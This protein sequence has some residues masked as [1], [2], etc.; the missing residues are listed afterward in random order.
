MPKS[1]PPIRSYRIIDLGSASS[2]RSTASRLAGPVSFGGPASAR[3]DRHAVQRRRW[4]RAYLTARVDVLSRTSADDRSAILE[5]IPAGGRLALLQAPD[6]TGGWLKDRLLNLSVM[7]RATRAISHVMELDALLP[8]I[9]ELVFES[10]STDRGAILLKDDN[11]LLVHQGR[12][13]A[14]AQPSPDE[15]DDD[16]PDDR[17][18]RPR[19]RAGVITSDASGD[20]RFGPRGRSSTMGSAK[21]DLRPVPGRHAILGV[22]YADIRAASGFMPTTF[23]RDGVRSRFSQDHL[24]L[25]AAIGH[26]AGLAIENTHFYN[27]KIQAER[28]AAV[29]QA[30][31]H[32]LAP[33][34]RTSCRDPGRELSDRH[35]AEREGRRDRPSWLDHRR[36]E[37]RQDLQHGHGHALLLQGSRACPL[38]PND[39]NETIT[40]VVEL[41]QSRAKELGVELQWDPGANLDQVMID[42]DGIHR[43]IL[44]ILTNAIDA[45]EG[46]TN[47]RVVVKTLH[48]VDNSSARIT[49]ADNGI[50]ID[51]DDLASIFQVFSSSKGSRGTGPGTPRL[52][53]DHPRARRQDC[54]HLEGRPGIN[55]R[56]R[57]PA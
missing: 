21:G 33:T 37:S 44:N 7:Y 15:L 50:G 56:D 24:M 20:K 28:L 3:P 9:L 17:R 55:L 12:P 31:R 10:I 23:T 51:E 46:V 53:K 42:S 57:P 43:A 35:G 41:M 16:L 1:G 30:D 27:D 54:R 5:N 11:G 25:M 6:I 49:I 13:L 8:Q 39:L 48:D 38:E 45:S 36:E 4:T 47:P 18:P 19:A 29:G 32:A 26:Q 2:L 34:S 14:R 52:A 22:L 40:D